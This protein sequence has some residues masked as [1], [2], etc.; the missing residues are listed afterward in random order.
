LGLVVFSVF[1]S[2]KT[3]D[4]CG[5][6]FQDYSSGGSC[7]LPTGPVKGPCWLGTTPGYEDYYWKF[8]VDDQGLVYEAECNHKDDGAPCVACGEAF[9]WG[10]SV[11][12]CYTYQGTSY[13]Y[14]RECS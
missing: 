12:R 4:T 7:S 14:S 9:Y 10:E 3:K 5:A 1:V 8:T 2:I 13:K 6:T 11:D